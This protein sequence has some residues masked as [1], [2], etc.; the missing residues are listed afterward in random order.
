M[1]A[2]PYDVLKPFLQNLPNE[3]ST[4]GGSFEYHER[5]RND[6]IQYI[7]GSL[8][9]MGYSVQ[10]INDTINY[11]TRVAT[12]KDGFIPDAGDFQQSLFNK[13]IIAN[14]PLKSLP[15]FATIDTPERF[16]TMPYF[17]NNPE[18][19]QSGT[20]TVNDNVLLKP[21]QNAIG[22][23]SASVV[24]LGLVAYLLLRKGLK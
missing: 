10:D 14:D 6:Y 7:R 22:G 15:V 11:D 2:V 8:F 21:Q 12:P 16:T 5:E 4:S 1:T 19:L 17:G 13:Q 3:T 9:S 23:I 20:S 18:P 24:V